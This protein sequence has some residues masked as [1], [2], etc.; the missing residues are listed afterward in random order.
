[1]AAAPGRL[2]SSRVCV[3]QRLRRALQMMIPALGCSVEL[4]T[5]DSQL[6]PLRRGAL[7]ILKYSKHWP[8]LGSQ[9]PSIAGNF[10]NLD[11]TEAGLRGS[12]R[13]PIALRPTI[14]LGRRVA[15]S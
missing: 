14:K 5:V 6:H 13:R 1:V 11:D 12:W 2:P 8:S 9:P 4:M 10:S 3:H 15:G 7:Q